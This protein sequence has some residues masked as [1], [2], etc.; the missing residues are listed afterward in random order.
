MLCKTNIYIHEN[1]ILYLL[2]VIYK[3]LFYIYIYI[4]LPQQERNIYILHVVNFK[5]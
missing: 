1:Y 3:I 2:I 4:L 5:G